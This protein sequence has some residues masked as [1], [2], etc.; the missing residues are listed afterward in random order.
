MDQRACYQPIIDTFLQDLGRAR[1]P[2]LI[3]GTTQCYHS[4]PALYQTCTGPQR[5]ESLPVQ[6]LPASNVSTDLPK[7]ILCVKLYCKYL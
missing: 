1:S 6:Q 7:P 4:M 2:S 3:L 5:A